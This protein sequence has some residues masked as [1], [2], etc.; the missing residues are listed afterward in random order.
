MR[1]GG[2]HPKLSAPDANNGHKRLARMKSGTI[3]NTPTMNNVRAGQMP[4][5]SGYA[6][7]ASML[8]PN[9]IATSSRASQAAERRRML[10]R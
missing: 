9:A 4:M 7:D 6:T 2:I 8:K 1:E 3:R 5:T 10:G